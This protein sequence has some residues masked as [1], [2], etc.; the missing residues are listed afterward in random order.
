M[1]NNQVLAL[2]LVSSTIGHL[3][4][5]TLLQEFTL[6]KADLYWKKLNV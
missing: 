1:L 6:L 2:K 5:G 4:R 3:Q